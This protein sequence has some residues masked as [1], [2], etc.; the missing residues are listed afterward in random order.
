ME[1]N[2]GNAGEAYPDMFI[3][4]FLLKPRIRF[5]RKPA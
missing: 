2:V 1:I 4:T 3:A 5:S